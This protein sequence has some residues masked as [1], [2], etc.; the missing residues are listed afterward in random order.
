MEAM[1]AQ[2]IVIV[3]RAQ[4]S[5]PDFNVILQ[6]DGRENITLTQIADIAAARL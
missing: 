6:T 5:H 4:V 1:D 3:S 2:S